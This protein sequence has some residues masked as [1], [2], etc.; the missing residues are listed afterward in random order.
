[1]KTTKAKYQGT[2]F[3]CGKPI[4]PG[5]LVKYYGRLHAEHYNCAD[6]IPGNEDFA[7]CSDTAYEDQCASSCG[8][9]L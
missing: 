6:S 4:T 8:L 9:G 1:M 2:C 3:E 7:S 5:Q